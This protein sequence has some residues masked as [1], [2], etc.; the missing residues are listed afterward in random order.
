MLIELDV[1]T[2]VV[3]LWDFLFSMVWIYFLGAPPSNGRPFDLVWNQNT[4]LWLMLMLNLF[5][6]PMFSVNF[7]FCAP[8]FLYCDNLSTTY[9]AANSVFHARTKHIELDFH[10]VRERVKL[11]TQKVQFIPSIDQPADV[12]TKG[13]SKPRFTLLRSKLVALRPP[14]LRGV[15]S[16]GGST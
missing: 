13:L 5:G 6:S 2:H 16:V 10:F 14:S 9:T 7:V 12:L 4:V 3:L 11:D 1:R 8:T 15:V